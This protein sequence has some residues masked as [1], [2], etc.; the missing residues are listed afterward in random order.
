[1]SFDRSNIG[2]LENLSFFNGGSWRWKGI[3]EAKRAGKKGIQE[4][5]EGNYRGPK[6]DQNPIRKERKNGR[7][8]ILRL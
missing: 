6:G 2:I 1:M 8:A 3:F 7:G 4:E 5:F